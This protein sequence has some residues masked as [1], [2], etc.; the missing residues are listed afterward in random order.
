[1][2]PINAVCRIAD[3]LGVTL[4]LEALPDEDEPDMD[5]SRLIAF[6]RRFGFEGGDSDGMMWRIPQKRRRN[7]VAVGVNRISMGSSSPS[8]EEPYIDAHRNGDIVWIDMIWV[9]LA[10]RRNGLGRQYYIEWERSLP[11]DIK[12]IYVLRQIQGSGPP[13]VFGKL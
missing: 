12:Y 9:P 4:H 3:R 7:I 2:L 11:K 1:M 10:Q 8:Q 5:Q 6:Y 13:T